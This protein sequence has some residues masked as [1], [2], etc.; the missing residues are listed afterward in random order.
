MVDHRAADRLPGVAEPFIDPSFDADRVGYAVSRPALFL[1]RDGVINVDHGYVH[2]P[3]QTEFVDGIF[4]MSRT[5]AR[6]GYL[7]VVVTNQ[8]GIGRGYYSREDFLDYT[9]WVHAQFRDRGA[10]L[11]ATYYCPH[12]PTEALAPFRTACECRKPRPGMLRAAERRFSIDISESMFI[13]DTVNDMLAGAEAG[14]GRRILLSGHDLSV[15]RE[16]PPG[17]IRLQA[18]TDLSFGL[19]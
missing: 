10:P 1:D 19:A 8:A 13:G 12:H 3:N 2:R 4:E 11:T 6:K 9:A 7:L 18:L 14:V 5:A 16:L 17:T 15:G